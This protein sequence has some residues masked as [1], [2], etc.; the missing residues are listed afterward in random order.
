[1]ENYLSWVE[2]MKEEILAKSPDYGAIPLEKH[3]K[4]VGEM[5]KTIAPHFR[6]DSDLAWIGGIMHD[7]GKAHPYFQR[8][9]IHQGKPTLTE[10][11]KYG[12][13]PPFRHEISSLAFLSLVDEE[14]RPEITEM[15]VAHH[16]SVN[17]KKGIL[18]ITSRLGSDA[19]DLHLQDWEIWAPEAIGILSSLGIQ[20]REIT[21]DEAVKNLDWVYDYCDET[22]EGWSP[23]RGLLM[24]ADHFVSATEGYVGEEKPELFKIPDTRSF[25]IKSDLFPI[26]HIRADQTERHTLVVAPTGAGKTN[27]LLRRCRK[28][29]FYVL[30]F[31]ASINAMYD[32]L[33]D[34]LKGDDVRLKHGSSK[35]VDLE[36][37]DSYSAAIQA[38][39]GAGA[40]VMTP[41]QLTAILF[42]KLS[43]EA[44]LMD[45]RRMDVI[46]DEIHTYSD[47]AQAI[48]L[49]L[50]ERLVR[51]DCRVH[52]G[53]ATMPSALYRKLKEVLELKG[54]V[55]EVKLSENDLQTYDRHTVHKIEEED[56]PEILNSAI[57]AGEKVL[58]VFNTV[59]KAQN[60]FLQISESGDY[61]HIEKLL[62][63]SRF[64]R[65]DRYEREQNLLKM[66]DQDK[67][68]I[69]VSTQV[70]EVSLDISFDRMITEAAPID[71]L[72]QRFGRINRKRTKKTKLKPVHVI[73]PGES[74]L[75]YKKEII[76]KSYSV[77]PD[78]D[79]L[80]INDLQ[81]L[82]DIVYPEINIHK[83]ET[84]LAWDGDDFKYK[85]LS[86][87]EQNILMQILEMDGDI[88]ILGSDKE[89][90]ENANWIDRTWMEIPVNAKS[91]RKFRDQYQRLDD[92]GKA[93]LVIDHPEVE[94]NYNQIGLTLI[95][96]DN[97]F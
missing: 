97:I 14:L 90:Y 11:R 36:R 55:A 25:D 75:P 86:H 17:G 68:C 69:L 33:K 26:S 78:K 8:V 2:I 43:F 39:V 44:Q 94:A 20:S 77:L 51:L 96:A 7:I 41:F 35:L 59:K 47:E 18:N 34:G 21:R 45:V 81:N 93:P 19:F 89:A 87:V 84:H 15:L 91:L 22:D 28:R 57:S 27:Y 31:Q 85:K 5:A 64:K 62:I 46:L 95:E 79:T 48:V 54:G 30:P 4:S 80:R 63:H 1:M 29:I 9:T 82:I 49:A 53:T 32:R 16:K 56:W 40:K 42:G 88:C 74:V 72:I 6:L 66:A 38:H 65:K 73:A 61:D 3:L 60:A 76:N 12:S 92:I 83:I 13:Y 37:G 71:A 24:A 10:Q 58:L 70:V 52:V 23:W 50:V 67:P